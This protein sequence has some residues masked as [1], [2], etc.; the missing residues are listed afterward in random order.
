APKKYPK[1]I[2]KINV[3][4]NTQNGMTSQRMAEKSPNVSDSN[5][6]GQS[7]HN[8]IL[9]KNTSCLTSEHTQRHIENRSHEFQKQK[10]RESMNQN[11]TRRPIAEAPKAKEY[12][13][14]VLTE[15]WD[16]DNEETKEF[17]NWDKKD[18]LNFWKMDQESAKKFWMWDKER[19][20]TCENMSNNTMDSDDEEELLNVIRDMVEVRKNLDPIRTAQILEKYQYIPYKSSIREPE[21]VYM[22]TPPYNRPPSPYYTPTSSYNIPK[23]PTNTPTPPEKK[24]ENKNTLHKDPQN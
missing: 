18:N 1:K 17:W 12:N 6:N 9:E 13:C 10:E 4:Q 15:Y 22:P 24:T 20:E 14:K 2:L 19:D 8:D 23:T 16:W 7:H 21:I 3:N 5:E 11:L